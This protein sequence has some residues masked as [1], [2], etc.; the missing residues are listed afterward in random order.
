MDRDYSL[1]S[2]EKSCYYNGVCWVC[3]CNVCGVCSQ[4]GQKSFIS[5]VEILLALD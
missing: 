4:I 1:R 5:R 3:G 2:T